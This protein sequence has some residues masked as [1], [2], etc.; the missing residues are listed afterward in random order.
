MAENSS[1]QYRTVKC[2]RR[3]DIQAKEGSMSPEAK[4]SLEQ[5][6]AADIMLLRIR[7]NSPAFIE[8]AL[9]LTKEN[10]VRITQVGL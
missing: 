6:G 4:A 8:A 10:M 2:M 9:P 1:P 7:V 3:S 5:A